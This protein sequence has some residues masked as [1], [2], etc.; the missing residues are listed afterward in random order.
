MKPNHSP[1]TIRRLWLFVMLIVAV[2]VVSL[3]LSTG[4]I[5]PASASAQTGLVSTT[6][7]SSQTM[8]QTDYYLPLVMGKYNLPNLYG[9][10]IEPVN[11]Y[12]LGLAD[13]AG[14]YWLRRNGLFWNAIQPTSTSGYLWNNAATL[15]AELLAARQMNQHVILVV[16][17][18]PAWAQKISGVSC[19]PIK[20]Q[21]FDEF[22]AFMAAAVTRYS[23]PP[24]YV[25][26]FEI[27]NEPDVDP[28]LVD[29]DEVYGCWG[30]NSDPYYGGRYYGQMLNVVYPMM[31]AANPNIKILVG[32]LLLDC[33]PRIPGQTCK[34]SKYL[35]GILTAGAKN[36]FDGVSFHAYDYYSSTFDTYGNP[37]WGSGKL[38]NE[39]DGEMIPVAKKKSDFIE[40]VLASF[41]ATGKFLMNTETALICGDPFDPPG[42]PGCDAS[43]T[44]PYELMKKAYAGHTYAQAVQEKLRANI[45]FSMRGWRNSGL[46]YSVGGEP[47]PAYYAIGFSQDM[48]GEAVFTGGIT[49]YTNVQGYK[50]YTPEYSNLWVMWATD[51]STVSITLPATPIAI[52]DADG[53]PVSING[54]SLD[55]TIEPYYIQMP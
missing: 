43:D 51:G 52:W 19:G 40:Q 8:T 38:Y 14:M 45:W 27:W 5:A 1:F 50:Y 30:D 34:P 39:P 16:R 35:E 20:S 49:T 36:S 55:L 33:D 25:E 23:G 13:Q 22:G 42:S 29:P 31:K 21:N 28:A 37:N 2:S 9:A 44:S 15:E 6:I 41:G 53:D 18:T 4:R 11:F 12:L 54:T 17:G 7:R 26:Y 48:L 24:Y 3:L 32:G 10:Q 47:R 46:V